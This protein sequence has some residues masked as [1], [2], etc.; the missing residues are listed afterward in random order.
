ML[1]FLRGGRA[2]AWSG[3]ESGRA[4]KRFTKVLLNRLKHRGVTARL[5]ENRLRAEH[6]DYD[7]MGVENIAR[8]C[9]ATAEKHW[10]AL[11]DGHLDNALKGR[12]EA[13]DLETYVGD[14]RRVGNLLK[15][16]VWPEHYLDTAGAENLV[17][18]VDFPGTITCLCFDLPST[19]VNVSPGHVRAWKKKKPE[20]F[21]RAFTN[22]RRENKITITEQDI[23]DVGRVYSLTGAHYFTPS[24]VP[25]LLTK[26]K[27]Q[28]RLG[29]LVTVP[30]RE[31][32]I[33]Y[34]VNDARVA[35]ALS[36]LIFIL[37][38]QCNIP[39]IK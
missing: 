30:V 28:G 23:E 25:D 5:E 4:H 20:L 27:Y 24:H 10:P 7:G 32:A 9:A 33:L 16:R 34:P 1:N 14:F 8:L 36:L 6:L 12:R 38:C 39:N 2:P 15:A 31:N 22:T 18:R 26:K 21:T 17:F 35:A 3:L 13:A 29:T 11:V 37:I 19:I